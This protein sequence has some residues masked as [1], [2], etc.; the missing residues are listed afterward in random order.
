MRWV[1]W[2]AIDDYIS[3]RTPDPPYDEASNLACSPR[4]EV[5]S[6]VIELL[7]SQYR[8]VQILLIEPLKMIDRDTVLVDAK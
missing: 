4:L 3:A 5:L 7:E 2:A 6:L 1:A 8:C